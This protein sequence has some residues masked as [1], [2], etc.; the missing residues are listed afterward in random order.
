V[1]E[2]RDP[3][4]ARRDFEQAK[5]AAI[6]ATGYLRKPFDGPELAALPN[7]LRAL[8]PKIADTINDAVRENDIPDW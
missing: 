7:A 5:A 1:R 6:I 8:A 4:K 3:V 2:D